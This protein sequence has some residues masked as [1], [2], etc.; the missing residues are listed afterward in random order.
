MTDVRT[1]PTLP[2]LEAEEEEVD[3]GRYGRTIAARWWLVVAG[4][5]AGLVVG[6]LIALGSGEVYQASV[7]I[8]PGQPFSP[9]G[10]APV[11]ALQTN[12]RTITEIVHSDA[13]VR[14][15]ANRSGL[16]PGQL[17]GR[18]STKTLGGGRTAARAATGQVQFVEITVQGDAPGKT[19]NAA[20]ALGQRVVRR[21]SGYVD[22]KIA[23]LQQRLDTLNDAVAAQD[24]LIRTYSRAVRN[25]SGLSLGEQLILV[26]QLNAAQQ[27]RA[28]LVTAQADAQGQVALAD[29]VEKPQIVERAVA[30]K[31]TARSARNSMLVGGL[32]GLLLGTIAALAWDPVARRAA[33][34]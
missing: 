13:A 2:D 15:A 27:Q 14:V 5:V 10:S 9:T 17:R 30:H 20:N 7:T 19:A 6:Y 29:F 22:Q 28:Q 33:R 31:T 23:G 4:L 34:D 25:T 18:I 16:Q 12:P 26:S 11:P 32:I 8:Y 24:R 3:L 21:T 1:P